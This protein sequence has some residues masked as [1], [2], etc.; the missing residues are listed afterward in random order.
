MF[1]EKKENVLLDGRDVD[2]AVA[3]N[4]FLAARYS[5]WIAGDPVPE[6]VPFVLS[7]L[8]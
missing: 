5:Y 8:P 3:Q 7:G 6:P 4:A 1:T 2:K